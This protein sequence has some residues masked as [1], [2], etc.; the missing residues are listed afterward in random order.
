[1]RTIDTAVHRGPMPTKMSRTQGTLRTRDVL[2]LALVAALLLAGAW[3]SR[4]QL[5]SQHVNRGL[6]VRV[7]AGDTPWALAQRYPVSGL[8]TAEEADVIRRSSAG[9]SGRL[10]P[11]QT[12]LVPVAG[13]DGTTLA[14]R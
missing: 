7:S 5:P 10:Q 13:D 4:G 2:V 3:F 1:M 14:M 8:T 9:P 6:L 12:A 11:G